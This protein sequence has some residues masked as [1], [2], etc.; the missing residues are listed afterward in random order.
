MTEYRVAD[1][2][3]AAQ[4]SVRN[5]RV[6]QDR[7]LLPPPRREGRIGLYNE[8]HLARLRLINRLLGRGY[9]F[10]TI[11][12]LFDAWSKG[13]DLADTLGLR[14][15]LTA[16]WTQEEPVRLTRAEVGRRFGAT[17]SPEAVDRAVELGMLVPDGK[18]G[19]YLV[20]SPS[21]LDAGHQLIVAGVPLPAVFDLAAAVQGDMTRVAQRFIGVLSY[22]AEKD[23]ETPTGGPLS[24][25]VVQQMVRLRPYVQR[26]VDAM[27]LMAMQQETDRLVDHIA[28]Q[29]E[30]SE[31]G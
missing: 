19:S 4:T 16:P 25:E 27:L 8:A 10:A 12:E 13:K 3:R 31:D 9:T 22:I 18:D 26:T 14:E 17:F 2:A 21:L 6:Y 30:P 29:A 1:L 28:F 11:G 15:A 20:P 7:G 23:E 24:D 5:V